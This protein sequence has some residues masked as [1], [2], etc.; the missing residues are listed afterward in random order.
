M[1]HSEVEDA[2]EQLPVCVARFDRDL[3]LVWANRRLLDRMG[4]Y[5]ASALGRR[6]SELGVPATEDD[7]WEA[8]MA[9]ALDSGD[10]IGFER[11]E[12]VEG[13]WGWV[14]YRFSPE[15]DGSAV[16]VTAF[17]NARADRLGRRLSAQGRLLREF[18]DNAP[19]FAWL[20][21]EGGRYHLVNRAYLDRFELSPSD[22]VGRTVQE[23][24]PGRTGEVFA[25]HD[26]TVL[27]RGEPQGFTE[28]APGPDGTMMTAWN[29]KFPYV[30]EAG[31]RFVGAI[32][33]DVTD[34]VRVERKLA[35]LERQSLLASLTTGTAHDLANDL[36]GAEGYLE[37]ALDRDPP[38]PGHVRRALE[39]LHRARS[40]VQRLR[41]QGGRRPADGD[42]CRLDE[43]AR[44]TVEA[45]GS[46]LR[47][48]VEVRIH[49]PKGS[50]EVRGI[51]DQLRQ[52]IENLLVNADEALA[53]GGGRVEVGFAAVEGLE[54]L[55]GRYVRMTIED[56]GPG[57]ELGRPDEVFEPFR[58]TKGEGRGLGL[59]GVR[60][61]VRAHGGRIEARSRPGGGARF[62]VVLPAAGGPT[63]PL[64]RA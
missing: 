46:V 14:E 10:E 42:R 23:R 48:A 62:E 37:A 41:E 54:G 11:Q 34:R 30:D 31:R 60:A 50:A 3:R 27:A 58:S 6:C 28:E 38:D 12:L 44:T 35:D 56:D 61:I 22:V 16:W 32:G 20:R 19:A 33:I 15:P 29:V 63:P 1:T 25:E 51:P 55:P 40:R 45:L 18:L 4:W 24:W 8:A 59:A 2:L 21:D 26:R 52:V 43:L 17:V 7:G 39:A 49:P 9:T 13:D 57:I 36:T 47:D 53:P 64:S 5:S